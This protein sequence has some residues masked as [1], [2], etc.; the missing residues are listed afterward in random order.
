MYLQ[1]LAIFGINFAV[2]YIFL[3]IQKGGPQV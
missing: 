3:V 1:H 2:F